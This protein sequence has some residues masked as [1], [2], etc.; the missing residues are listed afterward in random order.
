MK[1]LKD[2]FSLQFINIL[3]VCLKLNHSQRATIRDLINHSFLL[4]ES[5]EA[6]TVKVNLL[7]LLQI[8]ADE[9]QGFIESVFSI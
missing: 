6:K 3:C 2:R 4:S 9:S 7:D 5:K 1:L 8:S